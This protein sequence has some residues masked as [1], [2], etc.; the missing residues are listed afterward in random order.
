MYQATNYRIQGR[1][2]QAIVATTRFFN[3]FTNSDDIGAVVYTMEDF[4]H[5]VRPCRVL[6]GCLVCPKMDHMAMEVEHSS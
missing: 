4:G 6:W 5:D 3:S 2:S 1:V